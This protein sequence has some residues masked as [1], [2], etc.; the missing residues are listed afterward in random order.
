VIVFTVSQLVKVIEEQRY[1][2]NDKLTIEQEREL[3]KVPGIIVEEYGN[4]QR[5]YTLFGCYK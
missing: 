4:N 2:D 1:L 3:E 5:T